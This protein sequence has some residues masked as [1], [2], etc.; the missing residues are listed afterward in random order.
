MEATNTGTQQPAPKKRNP[1]FIIILAL[2][3]IGGGWFGISKYLYSLHH[4]DTDD[5]QVSADINLI[6]PRISGY[7]SEIKVKDNQQVNKG[8]TLVVLDN[9]DYQIKLEEAEAALTVAKSNL[10]NAKA[11]TNAAR[12][13]ISTSKASIGTADAQIDAAKVNVW[14]AT[15]DY[16]RYA[17]LIKDHSITQQQ[18][19]Q[20]LAAKQ[21]AEKQLAILQQQKNQAAQQTNAVSVQSNATSQQIGIAESTIKQKQVDVDAAKLNLSYTV[22]TAPESGRISKVN[23]QPGQFLQAGQALFSI[24]HSNSVWVVANFKETQLDK[25]KEGQKVVVSADAYSGHKFQGVLSSFSPAT[26][27][28]FALL[29]PDNASGNFV[30]VVQRLPV[31]IEFTDANDSLVHKLRP[32]MN[33]LVDVHLD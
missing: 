18:Y 14:R 28:T 22:I 21:T 5:A 32:G 6:I 15:Q 12:A 24:V 23:I 13:N 10:D 8:D 25:M 29:P 16:E 31:K 7:V 1:V 26:G 2:L 30:K 4:E 33:V 19:E 3:V 9:R 20:A 11:L 27:S 17:N